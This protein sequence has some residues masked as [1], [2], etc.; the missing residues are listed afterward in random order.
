MIYNN[1]KHTFIYGYIHSITMNK[2]LDV[3]EM[4]PE[5]GMRLKLNEMSD[6]YIVE[7]TEVFEKNRYGFNQI[8]MKVLSDNMRSKRKERFESQIH[9][10]TDYEF[11]EV[12]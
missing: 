4:K 5:V 12:E 8:K 6:S 9:D 1:K 7:I 11:E 2:I 10:I 3:N